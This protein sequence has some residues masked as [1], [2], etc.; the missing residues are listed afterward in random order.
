M[1]R[2]RARKSR[3]TKEDNMS[4]PIRRLLTAFSAA[5]AL[6]VW[7]TAAATARPSHA[8]GYHVAFQVTAGSTEQWDG[9][10]GNVEN[11]RRAL[12]DELRDVEVIA[13]GPGLGLVLRTNAAQAARMET[14]SRQGVRF[15][16]CEN[17]MKR[18]N[19]NT[20]DLLP[21]VGTVDSGVAQVV[22]R[23][24]QGW[25]TVRVGQ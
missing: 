19:V 8:D 12:G 14:L 5:L 11:L 7:S 2:N 6:F 3:Q 10:L 9:L 16:A 22:R 20:A 13:Y 1:N 4:S 17:T 23:Q 25:Q 18:R 15:L 21:F 24:K